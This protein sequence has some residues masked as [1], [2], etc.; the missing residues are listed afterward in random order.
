MQRCCIYKRI[1]TTKD[2]LVNMYDYYYADDF[3][4]ELDEE[5]EHGQVL[6]ISMIGVNPDTLEFA[7]IS[8]RYVISHKIFNKVFHEEPYMIQEQ[9]VEK[10][11]E[12][13]DKSWDN[14]PM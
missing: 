9:I 14:F 1:E 3:Y 6:L 4:Y 2:P 7:R 12:L 13:E 8:H 11:K 5:G 10:D